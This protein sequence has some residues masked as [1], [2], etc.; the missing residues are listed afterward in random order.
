VGLGAP[1]P[2][3]TA[4]VEAGVSAVAGLGGG[5]FALT[6]LA[7]E[8]RGPDGTPP[9]RLAEAAAAL[10]AALPESFRLATSAPPAKAASG[11]APA[12]E[13]RFEAVLLLDGNVRLAGPVQDA[14]S[15]AAIASFAAALFGHDRVVDGT[16]LDP[17]LPEGWP[18]RV[19]AGIEALSALE[20]GRLEVT[21]G[22]VSVEGWGLDRRVEQQVE[23][24]LAAKVGEGAEVDVT[25]NAKAAAAAALAARPRPE[26]CAEQID[27]ILDAE[28][29]RFA[30]GSAEIVPESAGMIAAIADVLRGCPGAEF[31]IAGHTDAQG[32][33][34]ANR[35]LSEE[36]AEAVVA[37]LQAQDLPLV[38]LVARGYGATR[39]VGDNAT[40]AGRARNRRIE[41]NLGPVPGAEPEAEELAS[42]ADAAGCVAAVEAILAE[43]TLEFE[44]GSAELSEASAPVVAAIREALAGC[45][46]AAVEIGG[47]T[48]AEGSESGNLRLSEQRAEAVLAALQAAGPDALPE[49][50]AKGYGEAE[51]V[52]DNDSPEGRARNRRIVFQAL[53]AAEPAPAEVAAGGAAADCVARVGVIL[54]ESSIEFAPGSATIADE[55]APVIE[56]VR[57]VL[58]ACPDAALEVGGYTDSEGSDS[59]NLR[60]SQQRAEAVLAALRT[61]ELPL[62]AMTAR[63][64]GEAEPIADNGTAEGRARNRRIALA[65]AAPEEI[66]SD[67]GS[68]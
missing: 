47:H 39:P 30:A 67:D 46:G 12:P 20:E 50:V 43:R 21:A 65:P 35:Q 19:L 6:D 34:A 45:P 61:G 2:E 31:E 33:E 25:F 63:G 22:G 13:A 37:A 41:F 4:A 60:L 49:L 3:W 15:R 27:A 14:T 68:Q 8:L 28:Q 5:R 36:R 59:G 57:E 64:Y 23:G 7:A 66:G 17:S 24:L 52:A 62:A 10:A 16:V 9:G 1:S 18:V 54:A 53:P 40:P 58:R 11:E 48:D 56:A 51:P 42:P 29:I 26:I 44:A 38:V 32:P 55:S